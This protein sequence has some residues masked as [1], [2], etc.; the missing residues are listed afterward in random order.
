MPRPF[1]NNLPRRLRFGRGVSSELAAELRRLGCKAG[2]DGT[3]CGMQRNRYAV[4]G[5]RGYNG[6]LIADTVES[7][8]GCAAD[9]SIRDMGDGDR[10]GQ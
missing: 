6:G 5:E 4:A 10:L 3:T 9:I 2:S 8:L 1:D 7:I